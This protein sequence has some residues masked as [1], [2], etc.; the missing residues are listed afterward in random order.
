MGLVEYLG[1]RSRPF[2]IILALEIVILLFMVNWVSARL[3]LLFVPLYLVPACMFLCIIRMLALLRT[4]RDRET[5]LTMIDNVT[6]VTNRKAFY[7]LAAL[8]IDRSRRYKHPF[9]VAYLDIDNF[10]LVNYRSGL[11]IGDSLL[12]SVGETIRSHIR[13]V[14]LVSRLGGDEFAILLPETGAEPSQIVISRLR[15]QLLDA[16]K[17]N[18]WS[19]TFSFG[20]VTFVNPP[21]SVE[22]MIKKASVLMYSAK[23]SGAN[24]IDQEIYSK[25]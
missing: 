23:N 25:S 19:V 21:D 12:H 1:R 15:S 6:G 13:D 5:S 3:G 7:N 2:L 20:V 4:S 10:K 11:T 17:K 8:E 14:D 18:D 24:V 16:M 22:E 9:T